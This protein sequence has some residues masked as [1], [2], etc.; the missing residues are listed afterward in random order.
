MKLILTGIPGNENSRHSLNNSDDN[1]PQYIEYDM[2][3]R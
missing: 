3:E 2:Y 1:G